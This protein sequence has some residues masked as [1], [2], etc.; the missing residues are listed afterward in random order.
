MEHWL[1]RNWRH[2]AISILAKGR[3]FTESFSTWDMVVSLLG[4]SG[5]PPTRCEQAGEHAHTVC[6]CPRLYLLHF[7]TDLSMIGLLEEFVCL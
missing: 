7:N 3:P 4:D 1:L 6:R 5:L 2:L